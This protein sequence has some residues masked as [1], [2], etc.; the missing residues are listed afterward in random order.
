MQLQQL[1]TDVLYRPGWVYAVNDDDDDEAF[2]GGEGGGAAV[3]ASAAGVGDG[4]ILLSDKQDCTNLP[5]HPN[6]ILKF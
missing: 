2:L 3:D 6:I 1:L 5:R 4:P